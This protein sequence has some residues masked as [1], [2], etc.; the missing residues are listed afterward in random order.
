MQ[1]KGKKISIIGFALT[2][3][4][5]VDFLLKKGANI[6][7]FDEKPKSAHGQLKEGACPVRSNP[8]KSRDADVVLELHR[9]SNGVKYNFGPFDFNEIARSALIVM[10]PGISRFKYPQFKKLDCDGKEVISEIELAFRFCRGKIVAIT[11]TNGKSTT[12]ELVHHLF[13][14]A[15]K[16]SYLLGNI[17]VPFISFAEDIKP[18]SYAVVEV[19]C[20]Q[21]E[22]IKT[23]RSDYVILT[24]I[25]EDHLDRY[26]SMA[27]YIKTRKNI[28]K[29]LISDDK[30]IM[31]FDDALSKKYFH[32]IQ[33]GQKYWFSRR[34]QVTNGTFLQGDDFIF[35]DGKT[36]LPFFNLADLHLI[37]LH[38]IE[39]VLAASLPVLLEGLDI[40]LIRS[41]LK[42]FKGLPHRMEKVASFNRVDFINDSKATNVDSVL[43]AIMSLNSSKEVALIM[44]GKDKGGDFSKLLAPIKNKIKLV[45]L[46]GEATDKIGSALRGIVQ[47]KKAADMKEAVR[48]SFEEVSNSSAGGVVLLSPACASFDMFNSFE[49][50]GEVFK[51]E[52]TD[53]IDENEKN[54]K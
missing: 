35:H 36:T 33:R 44:G 9:T 40:S 48:V 6:T 30:V 29:N 38:N 10:S 20:F 22:E 23:F 28:F 17:G 32:N 42:S 39:N 27:Q 41:G 8:D 46:I 21:L 3:K 11:G 53:I 54:G 37:G 25:S 1:L 16:K 15:G 52:I 4:A 49:H 47:V 13:T 2:G 7:V 5:V 18:D 24:N 51:K 14:T 26:P 45:V 19:S 43:K 34:T 12:T 50:R 31:N